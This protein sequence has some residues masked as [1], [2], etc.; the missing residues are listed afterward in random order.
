MDEPNTEISSSANGLDEQTSQMLGS[1]VVAAQE[2]PSTRHANEPYC[3]F[4]HR[5]ST[6]SYHT[7]PMLKMHTIFEGHEPPGSISYTL[8]NESPAG[9]NDAVDGVRSESWSGTTHN[10]AN[11]EPAGDTV[12][13]STPSINLCHHDTAA[14]S[15]TD[16]HTLVA[17][18]GAQSM[19]IRSTNKPHIS[20]SVGTTLR[21]TS[22]TETESMHRISLDSL[23][24]KKDVGLHTHNTSK[25]PQAQMLSTSKSSAAKHSALE[26]VSL[27]L[28]EH[29][30][31]L[32][33]DLNAIGTKW[34]DE[35]RLRREAARPTLIAALQS[36]GADRQNPEALLEGIIYLVHNSNS[37]ADPEKL[38]DFLNGLDLV[39]EDLVQRLWVC[40]PSVFSSY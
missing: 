37:K 10:E 33:M 39:A 32:A 8:V 22:M 1:P 17:D 19:P 38:N 13:I 36:N 18:M 34:H 30:L 11:H 5:S 2:S 14:A 31:S 27:R 12:Y 21:E 6:K 24:V 26:F 16:L 25:S 40:K 23:L 20:P 4:G 7:H 9:D 29:R 28:P 35:I 15:E 3:S